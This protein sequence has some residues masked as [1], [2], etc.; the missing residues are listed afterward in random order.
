M[1]NQV[2]IR[3][4]RVELGEIE[5][6][7]T[8]RP[9]MREAVVVDHLDRHNERQLAAYVQVRASAIDRIAFASEQLQLW[10]NCMT[11]AMATP[12]SLTG[13]PPS[14]RWVGTAPIRESR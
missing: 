11:T 1:D 5:A 8:A 13:I 4:F 2:K 14:T 6:A 3:G 7:L 12:A 9:D 10:Q